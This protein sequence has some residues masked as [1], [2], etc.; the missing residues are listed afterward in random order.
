[1]TKHLC[2]RPPVLIPV[3]VTVLLAG[4][5]AGGLFAAPA[6][7][8]GPALA[9]ETSLAI[10]PAQLELTCAQTGRVDIRVN[11]VENLYGVDVKVSFDPKVVEVVDANASMPGVQV[12]PGNMPDVAGGQ[13]LVQVNSVDVANGTISYAAI[14]LNPAQPQ[15]GS[16]V[17]AT[18]TFKGKGAGTSPVNFVSGVLSDQTAR[19]IT[20]DLV[21]GQ[22]KGTCTAAPTEPGATQVPTTPQATQPTGQPTAVPPGTACTHTVKPGDT[23]YAIAKTYCSTVDAIMQANHLTNADW[24]FVGQTLTIPNCCQPGPPPPTPPPG[25]DCFAYTVVPGDTLI[26]IAT[27]NGDCVAALAQR[28]HIANPNLIYAGQVLTVCPGCTGGGTTPPPP[29]ARCRYMH[30]VMPGET[31]YRISLMYGTTVYA[32]QAANGIANPNLIYAG[33]VLCI[34]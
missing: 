29:P 1:M 8:A 2:D 19:P 17:I 28:N 16:G 22:I 5:I 13:G 12:S 31:L 6:V 7:E 4:M 15:T 25:K 30:T 3:L 32:I 34:P 23:L 14:R 10:V 24:I 11:N 20:A 21:S 26:G 33:Q 9:E 18:V 27:R